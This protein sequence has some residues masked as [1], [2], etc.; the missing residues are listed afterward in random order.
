MKL[1]IKKYMW[2]DI[3]I[4]SAIAVLLDFITYQTISKPSTEEFINL[5]LYVAPALTIIYLV[6]IRWGIYGL[7]TNLTVLGINLILY[8]KQLINNPSYLVIFISGYLIW[9]LILLV[10]KI[11]KTGKYSTWYIIPSIFIGIYGVQILVETIISYIVNTPLTLEVNFL[12]HMIN[13]V[14]SLIVIII[15]SLQGKLAVDM[16]YELENKEDEV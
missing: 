14:V 12:K 9:A 10:R 5:K 2:I 6:Y 4:L 1:T 3:I 11:F 13:L 15:I 8:N 16:K 7:F